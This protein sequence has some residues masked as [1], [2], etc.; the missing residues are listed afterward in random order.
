M[1]KRPRDCLTE[2][3]L[4]RNFEG[5]SFPHCTGAIFGPMKCTSFFNTFLFV[6]STSCILK[7]VCVKAHSFL[8]FEVWVSKIFHVMY[9][10][11]CILCITTYLSTCLNNVREE[12][13]CFLR[14]EMH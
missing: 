2:R 6:L 7:C 8:S 3:V 4:Q 10:V 1:R 14:H 12:T 5:V 9:V 13:N 11:L